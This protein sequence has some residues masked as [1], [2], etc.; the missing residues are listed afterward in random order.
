MIVSDRVR[1]ENRVVIAHVYTAT[2]AIA[3]GAVFGVFQGFGRTGLYEAP[4][5]F[6]YYR[7]LTM[8]G[9]LMALVF[10]TFFI[11]GLSL[12]VT[13]R[14]IP[15]ERSLGMGWF[16][17]ALML[18]GT[19]M[20]AVTILKGDATVL[21]TFYAPLKASPW[22]YV[23]ATLLILGTWVVAFEIFGNVNY[24]RKNNPGR[25]VPLVVFC[26]AAT[27]VM[28][29]VATLGVVA[30]MFLLIPWAFGW[31]AGINVML[32]RMFFW[33][34]GHP[35]VYFW[36]MGAY[37]IW[38]NIIPTRY[39]G[40][41]FSDALTRLTFVM[42][43]LLS[44]P[45]GIHHEFMEPGISSIWKML[46]TVT[47]YGVAIPSFITAFAI[48]ASFELFAI[49]QGK[50]GFIGTVTALPWNDPTF[51][52][53]GLG[54]ILFILGG[55]GGLVNASYSMDT[56]VHNTIWIVGHF[57]VTV[58]GPVALTFLGAAYWIIPRITGRALWQP[59]L[60]LFQTRLWFFGMVIMSLSM[61]YAGLLGAPRR[62]AEVG[63][64]G[65]GAANAWEPY[66]LLAAAGGFFLF[67][68]ILAF[69]AVAVG[70]LLE[71][72]KTESMEAAFATP[73]DGGLATPQPLQRIYRWGVLALVLAVLAYA[74]PLGELLRHPGF[75]AP[76]MRT[77]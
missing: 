25:A 53:A 4:A 36:I 29:I 45:V 37:I 42:L 56:V 27:F 57:H 62:T 77:W 20:A 18:F 28:W 40:N 34:F 12:F 38:Y 72:K 76:G 74:G 54:M 50:R 49:K 11:T 13:Y 55:F 15:R 5:W 58:G 68:S 66:M 64:L 43:I 39:G 23:G 33:Y 14:A 44:T 32:T 17:W 6:D 16:G 46:H 21:Y 19:A 59:R 65:A 24:Y 7:V 51:S 41:L 60:A 63:Y 69:V 61:H 8:H 2:A 71:N 30:E 26:A 31:T 10:T 75:L 73:A 70:T 1:A 47:T 9:V 3:L 22:F 35:L 52:G 48:F 67:L